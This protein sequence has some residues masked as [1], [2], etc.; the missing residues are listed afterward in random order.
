MAT[1]VPRC[2]YVK[3]SFLSHILSFY[4]SLSS[5]D[6]NYIRSQLLP[7]SIPRFIQTLLFLSPLTFTGTFAQSFNHAFKTSIKNRNIF[8]LNQSPKDFYPECFANDLLSPQEKSTI[9]CHFNTEYS[10]L[11]NTF[12]L[13]CNDDC[14][15]SASNWL[16][17]ADSKDTLY[18]KVY[19][20]FF[21]NC[22]Y[23]GTFPCAST[24]PTKIY[25]TDGSTL[26]FYKFIT[27][28]VTNKLQVSKEY[29]EYLEDRY[30]KE[31]KM[32]RFY[33]NI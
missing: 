19:T 8:D 29:S 25:L 16:P 23:N 20:Q 11:L 9:I 7:L 13:A 33:L 32:C 26:S 31:I 30:S 1:V 22:I 17:F 15:Y 24:L 4:P 21:E 18:E 28:L 2:F 3:S 6:K 10:T 12:E 27:L 5:S 14:T